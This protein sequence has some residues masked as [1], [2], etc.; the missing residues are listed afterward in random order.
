M[1]SQV[2]GHA[3]LRN[4]PASSLDSDRNFTSLIKQKQSSFIVSLLEG[5]HIW[6]HD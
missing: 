4:R 3:E 5:T 6:P 1:S 2:L